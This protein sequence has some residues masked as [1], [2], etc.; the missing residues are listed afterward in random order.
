MPT[1]LALLFFQAA[2]VF[3]QRGHEIQFQTG[4]LVNWG[5]KSYDYFE[6]PTRRHQFIFDGLYD[7]EINTLSWHVPVNSYLDLGLY[8]TKSYDASFELIQDEGFYF[9]LEESSAPQ[10]AVL[11]AGT[12]DVE[13]RLSAYGVNIRLNHLIR[14]NKYK[15]YFVVS[16]GMM[17]ISNFVDNQNL[18]ETDDEGLKEVL[19]NDFIGAHKLFSV[20]YGFGISFPLK[21][22]LNLKLLEIYDR[23]TPRGKDSHFLTANHNLEIKTGISYQFY[24]RK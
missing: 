23:T 24:R 7:A 20:G 19:K 16:P 22:G 17:S 3:A 9:N 18:F 6:T 13:S 14:S 1:L 8:F 4:V 21:S 15:F 10:T 12:I 2:S 11:Y 5:T